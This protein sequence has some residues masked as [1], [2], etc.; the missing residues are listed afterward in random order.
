MSNNLEFLFLSQD[1]VKSCGGGDM[2]FVIDIIEDV[3][4]LHDKKDYV[5]PTKSTLRW[6]NLDAETTSG[7]INSMPGY[8]G[9]EFQ[10]TGIKWIS[11]AP[12]NP[13]KYNL[14]RA[15]GVIVLNN[16]ETLLPEVIMDGTLI[17]AMRT[18]AVS[19]VVAKYLAKE[20]SKVL[21][22]VGAGVQNRTQLMA[23]Q[24]VC[25]SI[26]KVKVADLNL[27]RA[28]AFCDDMASIMPHAAFEVVSGAEEA[29][30]G[31]DIF[32]TAT[33]TEKPIVK[34]GWV[35]EGSLHIHVGSHECEFD[36]LHQADKIVVDDWEEL[37]HRGV[38]T[39]SIMYT[40]GEFDPA[41][42]HAELGAIV[43]GKKK[44]RE[45]DKER[46]YFNSVGMGIEDVAV[47]KRIYDRA[48]EKGIG[49][50][51]NLWNSPS[52]V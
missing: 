8:I 18:G 25:P 42:I 9:G 51:L 11:S 14:P 32:I 33:V 34:K 20:D 13:F 4:S 1:D 22:L 2:K 19:G 52:F 41:N 45:N 27:E 15:A 44:G 26:E 37:K 47:A 31:S 50:P 21:G 17:S 7:R 6:G 16:E 49:Q 28:Q 48:K 24:A 36:V 35:D 23:I 30:R 43:N 38:E 40:E 12:S 10:A 39:I 29:V 5:L 3:I 46:I